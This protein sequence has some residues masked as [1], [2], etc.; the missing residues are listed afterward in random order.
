MKVTSKGQVTIPLGIRDRC[1]ITSGTEIDF[2][3]R[4]EEVVITKKTE[5]ENHL[6][7]WLRDFVGSGG[8][9]MTTDAF[10]LMTRGEEW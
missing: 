8:T 6:N 9:G 10:M 3:V 1:G 7:E 5:G 2:T 4:G